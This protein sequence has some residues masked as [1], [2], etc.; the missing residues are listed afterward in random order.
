MQGDRHP[1]QLITEVAP[2]TAYH[3]LS[4]MMILDLS[5]DIENASRSCSMQQS[6]K[7]TQEH[8]VGSSAVNSLRLHS[9]SSG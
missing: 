9:P 8:R 4:T 2:Y 5:V 6:M 7:S 1:V 3:D